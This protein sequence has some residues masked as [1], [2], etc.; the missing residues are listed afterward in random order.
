MPNKDRRKL[1]EQRVKEIVRVTLAE[2]AKTGEFCPYSGISPEKHELQ[3][4]FLD[5]IMKILDRIDEIK[6]DALRSV[7]RAT[8]VIIALF[9]AGSI[10]AAFGWEK[11]GK[12]LNGG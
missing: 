1:D 10:A 5:K 11:L 4:E 6:W 12:V 2:T 3:H 7:V 9:I 8:V